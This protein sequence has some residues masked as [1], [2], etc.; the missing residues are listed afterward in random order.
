MNIVV[1][2][3]CKYMEECL[4]YVPLPMTRVNNIMR[5]LVMCDKY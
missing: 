3:T 5:L 1:L 4:L 2:A